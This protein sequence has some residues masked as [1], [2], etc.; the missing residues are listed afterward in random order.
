MPIFP[1][2]LRQTKTCG[3]NEKEPQYDE[4]ECICKIL[5]SDD[6]QY[7]YM[8]AVAA[9]ATDRNRTWIE[10]TRVSHPHVLTSFMVEE[11]RSSTRGIAFDPSDST[12]VPQKRYACQH[13]EAG[14]D[15]GTLCRELTHAK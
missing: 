14:K 13:V 10:S 2:R 3:I 9:P 12:E 8:L 1:G 7:S 5:G 11:R 15:G 4:S 6:S